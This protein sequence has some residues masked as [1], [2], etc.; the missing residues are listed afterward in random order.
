MRSYE[1]PRSGRYALTRRL[2][3]QAGVGDHVRR[4]LLL[5]AVLLTPLALSAG[6]IEI[7]YLVG[8]GMP[9]SSTFCLDASESVHAV[10]PPSLGGACTLHV[11]GTTIAVEAI[12]D[13]RGEVHFFYDLRDPVSHLSC[14]HGFVQGP[15]T[16]S[17]PPGC[18]TISVGPEFGSQSGIVR[19]SS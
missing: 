15:L 17:I 16:I 14:A 5:A 10:A 1:R 19:V 13:A 7:R 4:T 9:S 11:D 2:F 8:T 12:D 3:R 18:A 6:T